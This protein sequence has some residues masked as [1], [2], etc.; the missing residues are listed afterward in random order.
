M[1]SVDGVTVERTV[2]DVPKMDCPSEERLVRM[3]LE[4]A[5]IQRL[6]FD[7]VQ[8]K[9][10][11][12]HDSTPEHLLALLA[13]LNFGAR[14]G[15]ADTAAADQTPAPA[16]STD[17]S[18]RSVLMILFAINATMFI[19]E[20]VVGWLAQ[21]TGLIA[22]SLDMFADAA[23]YAMSLYAV[24]KGVSSQGAAARFS[25][26]VQLLLA[27]G[28]LAEVARRFIVGNE[29]K[30]PAMMG[31]ALLALVAN[32]AGMA[33]LAKHRHGG[34]H[35]RASWIFTSTDVIANVGVLLAGALVGWTRSSLPDLVVGL[36]IGLVV[37]TGAVRILRLTGRPAPVSP[38]NAA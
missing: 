4:G 12:L 38:A 8:R 19:V 27:V 10:T 31:I 32:A 5:P 30:A 25:G 7:L 34:L 26:Y 36:A 37:L 17:G 16:A 6:D 2:F 11:A 29:P 15:E 18:E 28:V 14:I 23:V 9:V 22:D 35:M 3:A 21:S 24:G 33:L 13:P 1:R 20:L